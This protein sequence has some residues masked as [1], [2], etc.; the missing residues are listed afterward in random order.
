M[1][2]ATDITRLQGAKN[3]IGTAIAAKGVTVPS[4]TKLDGMATLI[5]QISELPS[6]IAEMIYGT[7]TPAS[8]V[9][10]YTAT[11]DFGVIP[12]GAVLWTEDFGGES[13]VATGAIHVLCYIGLPYYFKDTNGNML[14]TTNTTVIGY[15]YLNTNGNR[16]DTVNLADAT[17]T[18]YVYPMTT[19]LRFAAQ[20]SSIVFKAGKKYE[21]IIF[22]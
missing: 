12:K 10:S 2:I 18:T 5:G 22:K 7:F 14:S 19:T 6:E 17:S 8:D 20:A 3:D 4:G 13:E 21:Y 15:T 9:S 16:G 1:S 11:H